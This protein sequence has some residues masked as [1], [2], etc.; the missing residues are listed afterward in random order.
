MNTA[1]A[2]S[3]KLPGAPLRLA[4]GR[5]IR[6]GRLSPSDRPLIEKAMLRLTPESSRRRFF[7]VRYRLSDRELDEL[8]AAESWQRLAIGAGVHFPD[9]RIEGAGV[10]RFAR[11]ADRPDV[12]EV[13][14]TVIDDY[15][16]LGIGRR[17]LGRLAREASLRGIRRLAGLVLPDNGPMLA[18]L[19]RHA[20]GLVRRTLGEHVFVEVPVDGTA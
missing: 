13:A 1:L 18:L 5:T 16:R 10:A 8:T 12:A 9:G 19:E 4:D 3:T 14:V 15:Q 6:V 7:S 11:L 20:R 17:L 2:S